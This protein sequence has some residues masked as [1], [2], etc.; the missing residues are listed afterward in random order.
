MSGGGKRPEPG[1]RVRIKAGER[2]GEIGTLVRRNVNNVRGGAPDDAAVLMP[3]GRYYAA[4]AEDLEKAEGPPE[5][6]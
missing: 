5:N 3:D 2:G 1:D 4:R 6:E